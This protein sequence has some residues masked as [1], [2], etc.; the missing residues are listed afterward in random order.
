ML[1]V[2]NNTSIYLKLGIIYMYFY[3]LDSE[4]LDHETTKLRKH[5]VQKVTVI[6]RRVKL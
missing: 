5:N 1:N 4:C 2:T 3:D 6:K